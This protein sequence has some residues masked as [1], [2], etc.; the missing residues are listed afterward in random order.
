MYVAIWEFSSSTSVQDVLTEIFGEE[1]QQH[2]TFK[3]IQN[4]VN[5]EVPSEK[6]MNGEISYLDFNMKDNCDSLETAVIPQIIERSTTILQPLEPESMLNT[7]I[8]PDSKMR[9]KKLSEFWLSELPIITFDHVQVQ[10]T[11]KLKKFPS[12]NSVVWYFLRIID[13]EPNRVY[14]CYC[15]GFKFHWKEKRKSTSNL[16]NHLIKKHLDQKILPIWQT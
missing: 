14:C 7:E 16:R 10:K 9:Y 4:F 13:N 3:F 11:N 5:N 1:E 6:N 15:E 2:E 8:I 12:S